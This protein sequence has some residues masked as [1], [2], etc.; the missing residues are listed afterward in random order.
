MLSMKTSGPLITHYKC[1]CD[2]LQAAFL[3]DFPAVF[4]PKN[5]RFKMASVV[6]QLCQ[7]PPKCYWAFIREL[8]GKTSNANI[9]F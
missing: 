2:A 5:N 9:S 6:S 3:Q 8:D 7:G 4:F 1:I